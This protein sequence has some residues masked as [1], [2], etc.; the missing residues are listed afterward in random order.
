MGWIK[1]PRAGRA[2][3]DLGVA[4]LNTATDPS[5]IYA[6]TANVNATPERHYPIAEAG[7]CEP[8]PY[9]PANP[10]RVIQRYTTFNSLRVF[11]RSRFNSAWS[12]WKEVG[13]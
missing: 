11:H 13:V 4:D 2:I 12:G 5:V 1:R 3:Q 7:S 10:D 9:S 8:L 6:Q